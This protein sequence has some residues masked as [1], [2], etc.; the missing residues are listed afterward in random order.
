M[1][2]QGQTNT[3]RRRTRRGRRSTNSQKVGFLS[4]KESNIPVSM[5]EGNPSRQVINWGKHN[6]YPYFLNY[7]YQNNPLHA[8][9]VNGKVYFITS[10]GIQYEGAD[11]ATFTE[12]DS[13]FRFNKLATEISLSLELSN[14]AY[15]HVKKMTGVLGDRKI[16][17]VKVIPFEDVR[18]Q[19]VTDDQGNEVLTGKIEVCKDWT[20]KNRPAHELCEYN[21]SIDQDEFYLKVEVKTG[22]SLY[23]PEKAEVNPNVYPVPVYAGGITAIDT[24]IQIGLFNNSETYNAFSLG[25]ILNLN[26]GAPKT[27][28]EK[29]DLESDLGDATT[30]VNQAGRMM[31]LYNNGKDR[32][33][34]VINL[35]GNNLPDRYLNVKKSAEESIIH[36]HSV[37]TPILFGIKTEGSL[38]NATELE[39]GYAIMQANYFQGRR[40]LVTELLDQAAKALGLQGVFSFGENPLV[41]PKETEAPAT[42]FNVNLAKE[43]EKDIVLERLKKLGRPASEFKSIYS[44][45]VK[46]SPLSKESLIAEAKSKYQTNLSE[47][48]A[49]TLGLISKGND[50]NSIRKALDISSDRLVNIYKQLINS[51]LIT[52]EGQLTAEG[53]VLSGLDEAESIEVLYQ[54]A[55]RPDAPELVPGGKSR[56]FCQ[57]LISLNRVYTRDEI[58]LISGI[59][60][61]NVFAYRG[62]WYTNPN[63]DQ[64]EPGCRHEW[65]QIITFK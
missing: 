58:N 2:Q 11:S 29:Q 54:Y 42:Q 14:Y 4:V 15:L 63:T 13:T 25:T 9:I 49:R 43:E 10:G 32:E 39:I 41:L 16:Q 5:Q 36:S 28:R 6:E 40:S 30:G 46:E 64:H 56:D 44:H 65:K 59:E 57:E 35:N 53:E 52:A 19:Y 27:K 55:L 22:S 33:A 23:N 24:G 38:G 26:N 37:T 12:L 21:S 50:F 31:V 45:S 8:G 1:S 18:K 3:T 7:L 48:Q 61:Y 34:S 60:G 62:G 17:S 51:E 20:D 47:D